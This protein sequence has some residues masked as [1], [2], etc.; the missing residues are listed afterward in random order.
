[1][2]IANSWLQFECQ[3]RR[4]AEPPVKWHVP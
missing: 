3:N 1:M 2:L 4:G